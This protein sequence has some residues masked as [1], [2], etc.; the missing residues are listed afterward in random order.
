MEISDIKCYADSYDFSVLL[1]RN[2]VDKYIKVQ[3]SSICM[4]F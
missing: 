4:P 2:F 3:G 1:T